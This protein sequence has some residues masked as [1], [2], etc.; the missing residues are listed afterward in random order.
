MADTTTAAT[1]A[2][3]VATETAAT[4]TAAESVAD[5]AGTEI[6]GTSV[7][8][9]EA[10]DT[11]GAEI[12][13]L[14]DGGSDDLRSVKSETKSTKSFKSLKGSIAGSLRRFS[15][16]S[17]V[18]GLNW[19]SSQYSINTRK[20]D[21]Y[22]DPV[23]RRTR[24]TIGK[25]VVREEHTEWIKEEMLAELRDTKIQLANLTTFSEDHPE[26]PGQPFSN[27]MEQI[28]IEM[29]LISDYIDGIN[30]RIERLGFSPSPPTPPS[31]I[32]F[33]TPNFV[34]SFFCWHRYVPSD[35]EGEKEEPEKV[36][37][38]KMESVHSQIESE[39]DES[40]PK[41]PGCCK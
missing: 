31:P 37:S 35:E 40:M 12:S 33:P 29:Q 39:K 38:E 22:M 9:E 26:F 16:G 18:S 34:Q 17:K 36:E 30:A 21:D 4:E 32:R 5:D 41:S 11:L 20:T 10:R 13:L 7:D 2:E 23:Q 24:K 28:W 8:E 14:L 1:E 6:A 15:M 3:T 19:K 27:M 25:V